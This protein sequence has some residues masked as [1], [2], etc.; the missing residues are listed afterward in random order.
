MLTGDPTQVSPTPVLGV[1][2]DGDDTLWLTEAL[3]DDA[4]Q[5]ARQVV[6][7]AGLDGAL[8]EEVQRRRD[9][10]NVAVHGHTMARFPTSCVEAFDLVAGDD[11]RNRDVWAAQVRAAAE[12]VFTTPAPLREAAADVLAQLAQRGVRL[13]LLTKGDVAVQRRRIADSGL[14]PWFAVTLI[15]E[16]KTSAEFLDAARLLGV[17]P[18]HLL[19]VGNS[20]QSDILPSQSAGIRALWL[21]AHVW[22]YERRHDLAVEEHLTRITSLLDVLEWVGD[23]AHDG[24]Q[25]MGVD[26]G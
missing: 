13:A 10:E 5:R 26:D 19:S 12:A 8:W 14:A 20:V 6:E 25:A 2:F 21:P 24:P 22:E 18:D 16:Q 11:L 7:L 3:Y 15:V 23:R 4:R 17:E 9:V 1:I